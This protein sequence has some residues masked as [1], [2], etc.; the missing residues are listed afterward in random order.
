[1][2]TFPQPMNFTLMVAEFLF[3]TEMARSNLCVLRHTF[4]RQRMNDQV[5]NDVFH[6]LI[7]CCIQEEEFGVLIG[8]SSRFWTFFALIRLFWNQILICLSD[9]LISWDNSHRLDFDIYVELLYSRS[10]SAIWNFEY[11][12]RRFLS[13][14]VVGASVVEG[15]W[16]CCISVTLKR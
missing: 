9:K 13:V 1:M 4:M 16:I 7:G 3:T 2:Q 10:S 14:T 11:G 12:R 6:W 8:E 5:C 15:R